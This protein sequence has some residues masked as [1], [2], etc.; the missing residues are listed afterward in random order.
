MSEP[1]VILKEV[2][3]TASDWKKRRGLATHNLEVV[4]VEATDVYE[5]TR[6]RRGVELTLRR[7]D[8]KHMTV[9]LAGADAVNVLNALG[10]VLEYQ[11]IL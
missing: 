1:V 10:S 6:S 9:S 11:A 8:G 7:G 5:G 4:R 2:H 3:G